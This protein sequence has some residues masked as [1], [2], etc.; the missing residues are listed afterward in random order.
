V[1]ELDGQWV[2]LVVNNS[3]FLVLPERQ[4]YSAGRLR[5]PRL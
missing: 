5:L 2:A 4:R 1:A 3:R